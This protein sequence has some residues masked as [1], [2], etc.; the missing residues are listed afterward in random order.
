MF[1]AYLLTA[2]TQQ[3]SPP[4]RLVVELDAL[5]SKAAG[6]ALAVRPIAGSQKHRA[7]E[8]GAQDRVRKVVIVGQL[9]GLPMV[10]AADL[11]RAD[12]LFGPPP[13]VLQRIFAAPA[14][15]GALVSTKVA[16]A[17]C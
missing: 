9:P 11:E 14:A 8:A 1:K 3:R 16:S 12:S 7:A 2:L 5:H 6:A 10:A 4:G 17:K 15:H 13:G